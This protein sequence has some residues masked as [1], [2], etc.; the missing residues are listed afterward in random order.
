MTFV[1]FLKKYYQT[2]IGIAIFWILS[3]LASAQN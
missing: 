1:N 3:P 2:F